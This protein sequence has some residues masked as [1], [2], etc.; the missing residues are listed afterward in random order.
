MTVNEVIEKLQQFP[1]D[2][3]VIIFATD[4]SGGI[5]DRHTATGE[6]RMVNEDIYSGEPAVYITDGSY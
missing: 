3:Q 1:G 4:D 5:N 2:T 6:V